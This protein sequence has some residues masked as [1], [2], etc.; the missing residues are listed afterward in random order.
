MEDTISSRKERSEP[1]ISI[2]SP[3][4]LLLLHHFFFF[5]IV[6]GDGSED[7]VSI[8]NVMSEFIF[9]PVEKQDIPRAYE[10][11][12]AGYPEDE[13]ASLD[14]LQSVTNKKFP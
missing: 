7:P 6:L 1:I 8:Y 4:S 12:V 13:A 3:S 14:A 2:H 10:L 5:I 9:K 11:E